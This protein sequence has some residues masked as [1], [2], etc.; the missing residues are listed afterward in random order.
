MNFLTNNTSRLLLDSSSSFTTPL[1]VTGTFTAD[2]ANA[3]F[4][5]GD[6]DLV[7]EFRADDADTKGSG[8][9]FAK[10]RETDAEYGAD[11]IYKGDSENQFFY[12]TNGK[13]WN[14]CTF[15]KIYESYRSCSF[16]KF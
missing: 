10:L 14:R 13:C 11:M 6:A 3:Y 9:V 12:F 7:V 2:D 4:T 16:S 1:T 5:T 15:S 8:D